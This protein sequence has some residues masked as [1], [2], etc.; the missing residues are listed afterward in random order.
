M[1]FL[2]V[3]LTYRMFEVYDFCFLF[4]SWEW[5]ALPQLN[6]EAPTGKFSSGSF[7]SAMALCW[8]LEE[9]L[10]KL[11]SSCWQLGKDGFLL[12]EYVHGR[13][14]KYRIGTT[15]GGSMWKLQVWYIYVYV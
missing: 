3:C 2:N 8:I 6:W 1:S 11:G 7:F 5:A 4:S 13:T 12:V 15:L 9:V 14:G 10:F